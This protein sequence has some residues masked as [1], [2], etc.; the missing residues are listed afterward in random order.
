M[1]QVQAHPTSDGKLA[2]GIVFTSFGGMAAITGIALTAVG[3][4]DAERAGMCKAG[5]VTLGVGAL[6][7]AGSIMM[8]LDSLPRAEFRL[9]GGGTGSVTFGPGFAAGRF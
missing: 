7:T 4:S 6:V 2:T 8:I 9:P 5:A 1:V 3:C